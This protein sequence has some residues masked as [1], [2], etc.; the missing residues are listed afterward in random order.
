MNSSDHAVRNRPPEASPWLSV[1]RKAVGAIRF[2][3]IQIKVHEGEVVQIE[4]T[5]KLRL[6]VSH[7]ESDLPP[8]ASAEAHPTKSLNANSHQTTGGF[9]KES[10]T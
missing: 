7:T 3:V 4:T 9:A 8:T 10:R 1:V 6:D 2:G 5:E